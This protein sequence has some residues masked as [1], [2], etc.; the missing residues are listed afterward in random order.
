MKFSIGYNEKEGFE[1]LLEDYKDN[2]SSVYFPIPADLGSTGRPIRQKDDYYMQSESLVSTCHRLWIGTI[3]LLNSTFDGPKAFD[4]DTLTKL[5]SFIQHLIS[6]GLT[7]I[8]VTNML[9]VKFI[10]KKF[11]KIIIFCSVNARLKTLEQA[12]YFKNLGIDVLTLDRDINRDLKLIQAIKKRTWLELQLMLN[13]PCLKNCPYRNAHFEA[14]AFNKESIFGKEFEDF[15]CYP[16]IHEN[17][18]M[19]FRIPFIR[20]EDLVHFDWLIEHYKLVT[21]DAS[22]KKIRFLLDAYIAWEHHWNVIDLFDIE[23]TQYLSTLF[24][25]NQKLTKNN[26]FEKIQKCPWDCDRC[27]ACDIYI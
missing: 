24:I 27:K 9:Y 21:R 19:F 5:F 22:N 7:S 6:K 8:T 4:V 23:S 13:E 17:K 25:D 18:R 10:K 20:P 3:L 15:T 14:V 16:M 26:F 1:E 2:I 11:P 12:I